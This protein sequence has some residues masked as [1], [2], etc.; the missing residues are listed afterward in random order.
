MRWD[1]GR[2]VTL[3]LADRAGLGQA[4]GVMEARVGDAEAAVAKF[5]EGA[6]VS[7]KNSYVLQ[8]GRRLL[9]GASYQSDFRRGGCVCIG[10]RSKAESKGRGGT[11]P[12]PPLLLPLPSLFHTSE[13]AETYCASPFPPRSHA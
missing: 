4:W 8:V 2:R 6:R 3:G 1:A 9:A 13:W 11:S 5:Q 12:L 7:P 10:R